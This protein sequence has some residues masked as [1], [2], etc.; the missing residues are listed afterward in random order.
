[1]PRAIRIH[2]NGAP[3]VMRFEE[4]DIAPR[5]TGRRVRDSAAQRTVAPETGSCVKVSVTR[6]VSSFCG[7]SRSSRPFGG[8][9]RSA[10]SVAWSEPS[11]AEI[12]IGSSSAIDVANRAWYCESSF[13]A[14]P[15]PPPRNG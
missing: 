10:S 2:Q 9:L 3:E 1:M 13:D 14:K 8:T 12:S 4:V 6:T 5:T 7:M 15:I 11:H